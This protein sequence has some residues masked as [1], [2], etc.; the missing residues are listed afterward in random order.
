MKC[1]RCNGLVIAVSFV[2][3]DDARGAWEYDGLKC[4]NCGHVTD[5]LLM[6]NRRNRG[7]LA[8]SVAAHQPV[9]GRIATVGLRASNAA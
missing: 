3:G 9:P 2:G 6:K 5:P 4:L 1:E 8:Q 7:I